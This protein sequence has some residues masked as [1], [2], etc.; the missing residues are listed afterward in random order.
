MPP[1]PSTPQTP[2]I[3]AATLKGPGFT[4]LELLYTVTLAGVVLGLGVPALR[5]VVLDAQRDRAVSTLVTAVRFARSEAQKRAHT[6]VLCSSRDRS[7]CA[8]APSYGAGWIVFEETDPPME[9]PLLA[10]RPEGAVTVVANR[11]R[12]E[13]RP[14]PRRSTNGTVVFCDARGDA[15]SRAVIVSYT[16]RARI[17]DGAQGRCPSAP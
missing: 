15:R 9:R 7:S 12:F 13:F 16:G 11:S 4:L 8:D 14:F 2:P 17:A 3:G 6:I 1:T 10:G 5:G